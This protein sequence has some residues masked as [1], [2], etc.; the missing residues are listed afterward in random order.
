MATAKTVDMTNV[1]DG[2]GNFNKRRVP[3]GD[4]PARIT[5]VVDAKAKG[6]GEFQWL[7]TIETDT[8]GTYPYYCKLVETQ[9]WKIRNLCLAAGMAVPKKKLKLDPE[10]LVGKRIAV[11]LEDDEY[12]GKAQ[13]VVQATFPLSELSSSGVAD[14]GDDDDDD[15]DGDDDEVEEPAPKATK[16]KAKPAPEPEEDEDEDEEE[17][18]EDE[19][20][21]A[22]ADEYS[23]MDRNG[24]KKALKILDSDFVVKKSMSDD[25]L[26]EAARKLEADL[27]SDDDEDDEEEEPA[28]PKKK[29]AK[30][31][32][33]KKAAPVDDDEL[34]ELDLDDI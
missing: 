27:S 20:E 13:S 31:T 2:G 29:A 15:D 1:K 9:L 11:S 10:K 7:F 23:S 18:A 6:D 5:K 4:Y 25:D 22:P 17:D 14:D 33:K 32:A 8:G 30:K 12:D 3:A 28:P 19:E 21:E 24:L 34:E 16:K 26:R